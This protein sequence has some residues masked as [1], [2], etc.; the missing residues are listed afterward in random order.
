MPLRRFLSTR[1]EAGGDKMKARAGRAL[2]L[3]DMAEARMG[4]EQWAD[5]EQLFSQALDSMRLA[6]QGLSGQGD[7]ADHA[8]YLK[9]VR[10]ARVLCVVY[11]SMCWVSPLVARVHGPLPAQGTHAQWRLC[12]LARICLAHRESAALC[13]G[14]CCAVAWRV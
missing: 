11:T 4:L 9:L 8:E 6:L 3:T 10:S 2:N 7:A 5:A 1:A 13:Y 14:M 12:P